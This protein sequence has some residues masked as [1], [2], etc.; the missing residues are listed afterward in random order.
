MRETAVIQ[1]GRIVRP[2]MFQNWT[3]LTFIHWPYSSQMLQRLLP[4]NLR[5]DTLDGQGWVG[6]TPFVLEYS[7]PPFLPALPW[8][9]RFPETNLRTYVV[10]PDGTRGIWFFTLEAARLLPVIGARLT[11][12]LPYHW[13]NM[14]VKK[15]HRLI[16]YFS[17]RRQNCTSITVETGRTITTPTAREHF[18]T[19]RFRLF[20]D[21]KGT[22]CCADVEHPPWPLAEASLIR[23]SQTLTDAAA[24]PRPVG[25]PLVHFSPGVCMKVS[26]LRQC[27]GPVDVWH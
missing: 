26:A 19:A 16:T 11:F 1:P 15:D 20:S 27:P 22:L 17:K 10:G 18:L 5:V 8:I 23:L 6:L 3:D 4:A 24:L 12:G 9:S 13:A 25:A 7:R 14:C 2:Q 21:Y